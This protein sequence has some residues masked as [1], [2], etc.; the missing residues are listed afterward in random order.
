MKA[1]LRIKNAFILENRWKMSKIVFIGGSYGKKN[2]K[3]DKFL[4]QVIYLLSRFIIFRICGHALLKSNR[5]SSIFGKTENCCIFFFVRTTMTGPKKWIIRPLENYRESPPKTR[6]CIILF[7]VDHDDDDD[8]DVSDLLYGHEHHNNILY[9]RQR[10]NFICNRSFVVCIISR[11][12]S[13]L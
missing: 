10:Q 4:A 6:K 7:V 5:Y 3:R 11:I 2:R 9:R 13:A 1:H 12:V 8:D